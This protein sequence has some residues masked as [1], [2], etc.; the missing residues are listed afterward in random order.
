MPRQ[1]VLEDCN[2]QEEVSEMSTSWYTSSTVYDAQFLCAFSVQ[3]CVARA[4]ELYFRI[5]FRSENYL[6]LR[7]VYFGVNKVEEVYA[8]CCVKVL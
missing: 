3:V 5:V 7:Q 2:L 8:E 4:R 1:N 6:Y